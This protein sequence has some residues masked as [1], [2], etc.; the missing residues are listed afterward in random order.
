MELELL[1]FIIG[2]LVATIAFRFAYAH[3]QAYESGYGTEVFVTAISFFVV[4]SVMRAVMFLSLTE[5]LV[6]IG[7]GMA[8]GFILGLGFALHSWTER[9]SPKA[10]WSACGFSTVVFGAIGFIG[11]AIFLT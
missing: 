3:R 6:S 11:G 10:C 7:S 8:G 9:E 2:V 5:V 4:V 1:P